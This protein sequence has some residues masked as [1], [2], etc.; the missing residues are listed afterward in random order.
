MMSIKG[1][2][3]LGTRTARFTELCDFYEKVMGLTPVIATNERHVYRL[4]NGEAIAVLAEH[5]AGHEHFTT[6]PVVGFLV[7]DIEVARAEM[8][9]VGVEFLSPVSGVQGE[10]R[11]S[12][13]RAPDGNVY[14]ITERGTPK[15]SP[16]SKIGFI[17]LY[18]DNPARLIQFYRDTIGLQEM[19]GQ[20][21]SDD[22][23]GFETDGLTFA[24]EPTSNRDNYKN[25]GV[26]LSNNTLPQFVAESPEQL[27][28]M[29]Q[30]LE[31][32][33]VKLLNR[34][35]QMSYGL[36]TNFV[37]PDGNLFEILFPQEQKE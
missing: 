5:F 16:F 11:W 4:P 19:P 21:D 34:S 22:W 27:E 17:N 37:D 29:N 12:H 18:S 6:G 15:K 33:G 2:T 30:Q 23:Y 7:D 1:L 31:S 10:P 9:S 8:E 35:K 25:L 13:F 26:N 14:E 32:R 20:K 24:I 3:W 36:I 28:K